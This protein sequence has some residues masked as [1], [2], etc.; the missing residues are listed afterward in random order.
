MLMLYLSVIDIESDKLDFEKFY[1]LYKDDVFGYALS[2]LKNR[3]DA[4]DASQNTWLW[5]AKNLKVFRSK[6]ENS[7][8]IYLMRVVKSRSIDIYRKNKREE[9]ILAKEDE[10]AYTVSERNVDELLCEI[11]G[12][13]ELS[14]IVACIKALDEK[15]RDVLNLYYLNRN[16]TGEIAKILDIK[17]STARQRLTRG[18]KLL[19]GYLKERGIRQ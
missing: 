7:I 8:R 5:F 13:E 16:T 12:N 11:C 2:L 1:R 10:N 15:Y 17:E 4:E 9:K 3:E 19:I 18:R 14:S 6:D